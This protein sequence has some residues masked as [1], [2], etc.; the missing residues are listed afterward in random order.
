MIYFCHLI[1]ILQNSVQ[2][3]LSFDHTDPPGGHSS[4]KEWN[5]LIYFQ[6]SFINKENEEPLVIFISH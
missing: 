2:F 5:M 3:R 6:M 1:F 4:D